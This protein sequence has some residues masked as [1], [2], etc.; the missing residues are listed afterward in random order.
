ML[1]KSLRFT[2]TVIGTVRGTVP[3]RPQTPSLRS[4]TSVPIAGPALPILNEK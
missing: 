1:G 2:V 4:M 3:T